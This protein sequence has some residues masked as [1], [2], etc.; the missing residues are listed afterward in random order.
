[1]NQ[2]THEP[3][4]RFTCNHYP[5][6]HGRYT[7]AAVPGFYT[8]LALNGTEGARSIHT[9]TRDIETAH[10]IESATGGRTVIDDS[11]ARITAPRRLFYVGAGCDARPV[12]G[13]RFESH[14]AAVGF[15]QDLYTPFAGSEGSRI[16]AA[17]YQET[18]AMA[19]QREGRF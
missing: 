3:R 16:G 11:G 2:N 6:H 14:S 5:D 1:M 10:T 12:C 8:V 17:V 15:F 19:R 9:V 18:Y 7:S 13:E 4:D